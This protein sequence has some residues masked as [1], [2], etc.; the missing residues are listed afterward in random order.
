LLPPGGQPS[1]SADNSDGPARNIDTIKAIE[2]DVFARRRG[3]PRPV[4]AGQQLG[5]IGPEG[6]CCTG[7]SG[8]VQHRRSCC[9]RIV[10]LVAAHASEL[11]VC[12]RPARLRGA[13][14]E[15]AVAALSCVLYL[16]PIV[17]H[18]AQ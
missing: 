14:G 5:L 2:I 16:N 18:L 12:R 10:D 1:T 9:T 4:V 11:V 7:A 8:R 17:L 3:G 6:R 13:V 15:A